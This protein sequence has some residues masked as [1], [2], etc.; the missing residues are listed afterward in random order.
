MD[1]DEQKDKDHEEEQEEEE[2]EDEAFWEK[3][4]SA[5]ASLVGHGYFQQ[6]ASRLG[7]WVGGWVGCDLL[8]LTAIFPP[9]DGP[10]ALR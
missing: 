2:D 1:E 5:V 7:G 9:N 10:K 4:N 6:P 8:S 3:M